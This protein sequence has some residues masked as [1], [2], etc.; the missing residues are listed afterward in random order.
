M[1]PGWNDRCYFKSEKYNEV[2]TVYLSEENNNYSFKD[3]YFKLYMKDDAEKYFYDIASNYGKFEI[4]VRFGSPTLSTQ[5]YT[6]DEYINSGKCSVEVYFFSN[7]KLTSDNINTIL[8]KIVD[9][10][11]YGYFNFDVT[12]YSDLLSNYTLSDILNN[13]SELLVSEEE[14]HIDSNLQIIKN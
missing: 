8:N 11:I 4:K 13:T 5:I 14:Y 7:T 6:F 1:F 12:N 3:D 10:K 2:V 9:D